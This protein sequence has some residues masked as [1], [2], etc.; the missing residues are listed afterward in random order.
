MKCTTAIPPDP[1]TYALHSMIV[2]ISLVLGV[3]IF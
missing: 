1:V 3:L 2:V